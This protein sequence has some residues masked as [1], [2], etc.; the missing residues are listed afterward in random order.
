MLAMLHSIDACAGLRI[1]ACTTS[2][3]LFSIAAGAIKTCLS[4]RLHGFAMHGMQSSA[5]KRPLSADLAS[6]IR[7]L[8]IGI[9][10]MAC[11]RLGR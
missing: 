8:R 3:R 5:V 7:F 2:L 4:V 6:G 1:C 11:E 9:L 10:R